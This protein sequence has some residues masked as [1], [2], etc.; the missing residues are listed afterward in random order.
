MVYTLKIK[1]L[2]K[3]LQLEQYYSSVSHHFSG[4][5][6]I[7]LIVPTT[8]EMTAVAVNTINHEIACEMVDENENNVSYIL[9][10]RS[11]I[12]KTPLMMANSI[13]LIDAGYRGPIMAKVWIVDR[14]LDEYTVQEN[15]KLFQICAPNFTPIKVQ[16]VDELSSSD[17]G[18]GGFGS[19]SAL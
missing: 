15:T 18:V 8:L 5:S 17:R 14:D 19:T 6:G 13:G 4:D 3:D 1:I 9:M 10:P 11:S 2:N 16:L 12:S 7:D